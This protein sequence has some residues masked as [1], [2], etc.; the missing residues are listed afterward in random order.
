MSRILAIVLVTFLGCLGIAE[1]IFRVLPV[2][3]T[4]MIGYHVDPDVMTYPPRHA[5]TIS[6]GWDLRNPQR[7][8]ANNWGFAN[9]IDFVADEDAVA[10]IG[11]SYVEASML[12]P[13]DRP[14]RRL[15]TELADRRP[16][17]GLGSP[18]TALIE[19]PQRVRLAREK[20]GVRDFVIWADAGTALQSICS[21]GNVH[22]RCLD[23][24]TLALRT[25]HQMPASALKKAARHSALL[26]YVFAQLK[27][28]VG[29]LTRAALGHQATQKSTLAAASA[30]GP[31]D[32][33]KARA[34][35]IIDSAV[36]Q[37]FRDIE[38]WRGDARVLFIIDGRRTAV[39]PAND[40]RDLERQH[41]IQELA[42]RGV[43]VIDMEPVYR[44][45]LHSSRLS[46]EV[47]PYDAHLNALGVQIVM[48]QVASRLSRW[49]R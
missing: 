12:D 11:N 21:Q 26:Q 3:T 18:G 46:L 24:T 34:F 42:N 39:A 19:F 45:H 20:F 16:V 48:Q 14:A 35:E 33:A 2:S 41:F 28:N 43:E 8:H 36:A 29:Q 44:Q 47:G 38:P 25:E 10:L 31:S 9:H 1:G 30:T 23:P 22:S 6:T 4:T 7:I 37:F 13:L 15:Q 49:E 17:Y 32:R 5:F 40:L 27:V